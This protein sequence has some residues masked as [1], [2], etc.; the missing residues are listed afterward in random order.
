[1]ID[2]R[3]KFSMPASIKGKTA[4]LVSSKNNLAHIKKEKIKNFEPLASQ[5]GEYWS[6]VL[7]YKHYAN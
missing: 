2:G 3:A 1:M 6:L 5:D 4:K 7:G